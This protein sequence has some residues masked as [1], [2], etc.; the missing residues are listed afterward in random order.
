MFVF[1]RE[2]D[3]EAIS[4]ATSLNSIEISTVDFEIYERSAISK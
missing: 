1:E 3:H 4:L 2:R